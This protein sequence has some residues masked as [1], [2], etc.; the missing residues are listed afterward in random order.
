MDLGN[1][2]NDVASTALRI[3]KSMK[4]DWMAFGRKPTG[5]VAAAI[6]IASRYHSI[7]FPISDMAPIMGVCV[8][9][10]K[11]RILEFKQ[12]KAA[13]LTL[14]EFEKIDLIKDIQFESNPP[15]FKPEIKP[16]VF[17][18]KTVIE[19]IRTKISEE[20]LHKLTLVKQESDLANTDQIN[21][22]D[23]LSAISE[24]EIDSYL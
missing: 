18:S 17:D 20:N 15:S 6:L 7:I 1:K 19:E 8:E 11:R 24:T 14:D 13:S 12:T 22:I 9:T 4:R 21:E 5:L 2:E 16:V 23:T 10:I 3:I